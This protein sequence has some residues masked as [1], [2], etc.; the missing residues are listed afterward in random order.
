MSESILVMVY[1]SL[2]RVFDLDQVARASVVRPIRMGCEEVVNEGL[3]DNRASIAT[4]DDETIL[5]IRVYH[6]RDFSVVDIYTLAFDSGGLS[7]CH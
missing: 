5:G 7:S 1:L 2:P 6:D 4:C 3:T